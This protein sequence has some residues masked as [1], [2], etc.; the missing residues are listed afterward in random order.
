VLAAVLGEADPCREDRQRITDPF[1][2]AGVRAAGWEFRTWDVGVGNGCM[3][4]DR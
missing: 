1:V 2:C 3:R 4:E